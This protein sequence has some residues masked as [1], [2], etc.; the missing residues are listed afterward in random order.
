MGQPEPI[1]SLLLDEVVGFGEKLSDSEKENYS[2]F[3]FTTIVEVPENAQYDEDGDEEHP[4]VQ[5][6]ATI[7]LDA[8][9]ECPSIFPSRTRS[10][11]M[12]ETW[13]RVI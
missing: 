12:S 2:V 9:D 13:T 8:E 5:I 11:L 10:I 1:F 6:A 7:E 3:V 4:V